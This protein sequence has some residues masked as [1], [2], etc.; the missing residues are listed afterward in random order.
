[1]QITAILA[2]RNE[3]PYLANCLNHLIANGVSYFIIDNDSDD[4]SGDLIREP[5]FAANLAGYERYP[6]Q[7]VFDWEGLMRARETVAHSL[8]ADWIITQA[9]DEILHPYTTETLAEAIVRID[10]AGYDV[11]DFNEF[12][13]LPIDH[14]YVV[15]RPATQPMQYHY[16]YQPKT[17]RLMRARRRSLK[18]SHILRGGHVLEGEDFRLAPERLALRHYI[19]RNQEHALEKYQ[20][21]QFRAEELE[22]GWHRNRVGML[23]ERFKF[24]AADQLDRLV[25]PATRDIDRSNPRKTHYWL[26]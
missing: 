11:I 16:W 12:V 21:R 19:F 4:G 10:A 5:R 15:D 13:F 20:R 2:L 17:P 7:G 6:F 25:D 24:P 22:R 9:P 18:V 14:D 3:Q 1:M 26:W 8:A 23:P